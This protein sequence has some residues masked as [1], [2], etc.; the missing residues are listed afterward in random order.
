MMRSG[1]EPGRL[2][3]TPSERASLRRLHRDL[4]ATD[5]HLLA[6]LDPMRARRN[7]IISSVLDAMGLGFREFSGVWT[8]FPLSALARGAE[9]LGAAKTA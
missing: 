5:T 6:L 4:A 9:H 7:L 1:R 3:L 2:T 8:L